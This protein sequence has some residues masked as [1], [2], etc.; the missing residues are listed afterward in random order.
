VPEDFYASAFFNNTKNIVS[1][2]F[3]RDIWMLKEQ[4]HAAMEKKSELYFKRK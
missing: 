1:P 4:R 3:Y 2:A